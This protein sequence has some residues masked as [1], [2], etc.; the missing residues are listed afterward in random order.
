MRLPTWFGVAGALAVQGV[1]RTAAWDNATAM[2][3][4]DRLPECSVRKLRKLNIRGPQKECSLS[5]FTSS[6]RV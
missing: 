3:L 6:R 2:A 5:V 1:N 4:Y